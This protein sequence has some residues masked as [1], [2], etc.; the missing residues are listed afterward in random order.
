MIKG[1]FSEDERSRQ[2]VLEKLDMRFDGYYELFDSEEA[3]ILMRSIPHLRHLVVNKTLW[4][5]SS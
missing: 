4:E 2:L 5:V 1:T 3:E